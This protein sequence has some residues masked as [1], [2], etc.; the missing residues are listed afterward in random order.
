MPAIG[1]EVRTL[2]E[3]EVPVSS[4]DVAERD[5]ALGAALGKV[6]VKVTGNR[7]PQSHPGIVQ[8]MSNPSPFV[9]Q[10]RYVSLSLEA[11][12]ESAEELRLHASFDPPA[13]DRLAR[14]LGLP[15]WGRQR[16]SLL[17]WLAVEDE[18]GRSLI[19]VD[20]SPGISQI[21]AEVAD[22]RGVPIALP[23][24]GDAERAGVDVSDIWTGVAERVE[25]ASRPYAADA[26]L[27]SRAYP[28]ET[29]GFG[30]RVR[31]LID[32]SAQDWETRGEMMEEV[33]IEGTE[34][35]I[36]RL[37]QRYAQ[38]L[39]AS[40]PVGVVV[41]VSDVGSV[42]DYARVLAYLESLDGVSRVDVAGLRAGKVVY[43]LQASGGDARLRQLIALGGILAAEGGG[44][45]LRYHLS[46]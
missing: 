9:Q 44:E 21:F 4:K 43:A 11:V 6:M 23:H 5:V 35:A 27:L 41:E 15:V 38:V 31:L 33:L 12:D 42:E 2:Y 19:G 36:D 13:V 7:E 16:P 14:E 28:L 39:T 1:A 22:R 32:G 3:A 29:G 34:E 40:G 30:G 20:D 25:A 24:L 10:Y 46:H 18:S 26:I 37:A 45:G 8:A 17:V